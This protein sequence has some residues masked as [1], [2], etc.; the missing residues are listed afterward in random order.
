MKI[1][2]SS[3]PLGDRLRHDEADHERDH[4]RAQQQPEGP[5]VHVSIVSP[6]L[7]AAIC[8]MFE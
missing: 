1:G 3:R 5:D 6:S 7:T 8:A 2:A 4:D